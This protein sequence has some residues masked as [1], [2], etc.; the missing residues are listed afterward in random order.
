MMDGLKA[1]KYYM[2]IKLH[3]NNDKFNVF[4]NRGRINCPRE[5]FDNRNDRFT[6]EKLARKYDT[7]KE[8]VQFYA[9]NFAYGNENVIYSIEEG[10][11]N[12]FEWNRRKE[13]MSKIFS[14]D[15]NTIILNAQMNDLQKDDIFNFTLNDYPCIIKLFLGGKITLESVRILDDIKPFLDK[16]I[17]PSFL[18]IMERE[19]RRIRK[20]TGFVKYDV[21][22][23]KP[24]YEHFIEEFEELSYHG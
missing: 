18:M 1:Y 21:N 16:P 11:E 9:S 22:R 6:F 7:D 12:Y 17:S 2:A 15:C 24:I 14:D 20:A 13:S 3:F 10:E 4:E 8:L 19:I 5:T 23:V